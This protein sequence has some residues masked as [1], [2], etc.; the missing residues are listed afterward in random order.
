[1]NPIVFMSLRARIKAPA[2]R[3]AGSN[4]N[5]N[6]GYRK[7]TH[8]FELILSKAKDLY[9]SPRFRKRNLGTLRGSPRRPM[10][11]SR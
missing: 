7:I 3:K 8:V 9:R 5:E 2:C 10:A 4:L 6:M 11:F 1:M